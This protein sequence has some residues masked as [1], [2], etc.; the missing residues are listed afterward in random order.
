MNYKTIY[1]NKNIQ[2]IKPNKLLFKIFPYRNPDDYFLDLGCGQGRDSLFMVKKGYKVIAVDR[3]NE[4]LKNIEKYL[5]G[6]NSL[7]ERIKLFCQ[8]ITTFNIEKN[9]YEIINAFNSLQFL[10]KQDALQLIE[11][12]KRGLKTGGYAII[13]SFTINDPL[14]QRPI[15][16][17][18]CF[19]KPLELQ[20]LFFDFKIIFYEEKIIADAPHLGYLKPHKH[21]IV[22]MIA[23]RII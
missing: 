10:L 6:H 15:N 17:N 8:D 12:I 3:S 1:Q 18:K 9:K 22:E 2:R 21:Y 23:Q 5:E 11:K 16:Q 19:F 4:D 7:K 14:Y 13:S 20:K